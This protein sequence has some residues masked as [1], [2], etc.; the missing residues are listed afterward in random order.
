MRW[1]R[2]KNGGVIPLPEL[3]PHYL[4]GQA[5]NDL[6]RSRPGA[7]AIDPIDITVAA[8]EQ[9]LV[10]PVCERRGTHVSWS[11]DARGAQEE[12]VEHILELRA[13]VE[14]HLSFV[15]N[16]EIAAQT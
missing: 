1:G 16:T 4:E 9:A 13:D 2:N 8:R 6:A 15:R 12:A 5:C 11:A 10:V 7:G 14:N 3:L